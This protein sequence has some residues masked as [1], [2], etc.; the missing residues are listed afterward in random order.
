MDSGAVIGLAA[1]EVVKSVT[2]VDTDQVVIVVS[3]LDLLG[4]GPNVVVVDRCLKLDVADT[5]L[6]EASCLVEDF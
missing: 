1:F 5:G 3:S 2:W 4:F 6:E